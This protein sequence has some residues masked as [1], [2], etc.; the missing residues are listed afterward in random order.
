M[1]SCGA[2][3]F[4]KTSSEFFSALSDVNSLGGSAL[5]LAYDLVHRG[6]GLVSKHVSIGTGGYLA[7]AGSLILAVQG[8]HRLRR[9]A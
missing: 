5:R 1:V 6:S 9:A 3:L 8:I 7:F 2:L 4:S